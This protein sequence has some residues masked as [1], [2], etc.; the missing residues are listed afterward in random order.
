MSYQDSYDRPQMGFALPRVTPVVRWLMIANL[1]VWGLET[2]LY[3]T[4]ESA[5]AGML[6]LLGLTPGWWA[7]LWFPVW[8]VVSYGFLHA[9]RELGHVFF[10]M[11]TLFFF[12]T[13]LEGILGSRRFAVFYGAAL[14]VGALA[15]LLAELTWGNATPAI[16]ASGATMA[17]L[18]AM[19]VMRPNLQVL[20][21]LFPVKL[22]YLAVAFVLMDLLRLGD[23]LKSGIGGVAYMVHLGGAALGFLAVRKGW[24]W[25]D[26]LEEHQRRKA[27]K[28]REQGARDDERMDELLAKIHREGMSALSRQEREFLKRMS[29]R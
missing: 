7:N 16:G 12:G 18:I 19:A 5:L 23:D 8:Q 6:D 17:V 20:L 25:R 1:A 21:L 9:P 24:I 3:F 4:S 15:H 22:K 28:A 29:K 26:P 2:L 14:V 10:N 13:M 11:L 27:V